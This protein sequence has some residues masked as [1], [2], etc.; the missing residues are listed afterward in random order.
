MQE[1]TDAVAQIVRA[2]ILPLASFLF[3]SVLSGW[4]DAH[5]HWGGQSAFL[6]LWI[7]MLI[8]PK[9]TLTD[10]QEKRLAS[11]LGTLWPGQVDT[12]TS[13]PQCACDVL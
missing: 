5:P 8:S 13:P 9:H 10:T 2:I 3:C 6:S 7:Q 11:Y 4:N 1:T 12:Y